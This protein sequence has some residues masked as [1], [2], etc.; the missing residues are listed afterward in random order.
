MLVAVAGASSGLLLFLS[1]YPA[2]VWPLQ[3]VAFIP[4]LYALTRWCP[5]HG[6]ALLAGVSL[7]VFYTVPLLVVL[8]FPL[9]M[10]APLGL[11]LTLIWVLF[12][13]GARWLLRWPAV[14]A[15][16]ATGALA[17]LVEW[18]DFTVVPIW[19]TAQCFSIRGQSYTH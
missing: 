14:P 16:L 6:S 15:A 13:V 19:G 4:V 9:L 7:G 17:V 12:A 8:S 18:V 5:G 3:I 11:Y 1:D 2:H 10:G